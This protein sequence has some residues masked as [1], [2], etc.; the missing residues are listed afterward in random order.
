MWSLYRRPH[1]VL[2]FTLLFASTL[3]AQDR[4]YYLGT[5]TEITGGATNR[6][7][8]LNQATNQPLFFFYGFYPTI[9]LT[10]TG[11]RSILDASY[12][13]GLSRSAS[14]TPLHSNSHAASLNFT[15]P[16]SQNWKIHLS[17]SF[18]LTDDASAFNGFRGV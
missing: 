14:H 6:L 15:T 5:A 3:T 8:Q 18:Q 12:S 17:D 11:A 7:G 1:Y 9:K 2:I 13:F 10:G 4:K 16:V